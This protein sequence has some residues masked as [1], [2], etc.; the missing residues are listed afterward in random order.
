MFPKKPKIQE[1]YT[2]K[3]SVWFVYFNKMVNLKKA[4]TLFQAQ[5]RDKLLKK[6]SNTTYQY[7]TPQLIRYCDQYE[8]ATYSLLC[9]QYAII[10]NLG[11]FIFQKIMLICMQ[12]HYILNLNY[13]LYYYV[14][15]C[16]ICSI[17]SKYLV[18]QFVKPFHFPPNQSCIAF[19]TSQ[20][21][22]S[23][24]Q[25]LQFALHSPLEAHGCAKKFYWLLLVLGCVPCYLFEGVS[26]PEK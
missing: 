25:T 13:V 6:T 11:D 14:R 19:Q 16:T 5:S 23:R 8:Q 4:L 18:P 24:P 22:S 9:L 12:Q 2:P 15:L 7:T 17:Y 26:S 20:L 10:Q 21:L 1:T 3:F